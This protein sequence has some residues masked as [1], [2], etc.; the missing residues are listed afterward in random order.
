MI[1][2]LRFFVLIDLTLTRYLLKTL[3]LIICILI[4]AYLTYKDGHSNV[5]VFVDK[6][7]HLKV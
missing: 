7:D 3:R 2:L 1:K 4:C 5:D 6:F